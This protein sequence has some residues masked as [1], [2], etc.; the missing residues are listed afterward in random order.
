MPQTDD[1]VRLE[2][3]TA[4]LRVLNM[5]RSNTRSDRDFGQG[6]FLTGVEAQII[7]LVYGGRTVAVE[8][9]NEIGVSQS[10]VSQV[11]S[12]LKEKGLV[13]STRDE[14]NARR[15]PLALTESGQEAANAVV[16]YYESMGEAVLG[17]SGVELRH[18]ATFVANLEEFLEGH[19]QR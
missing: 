2:I 11:L 10:A 14:T 19:R 5:V 15:R 17:A 12:R 3:T 7:G 9:A 4:L 8:L 1:E 18:Y 6:I 16:S 13:T